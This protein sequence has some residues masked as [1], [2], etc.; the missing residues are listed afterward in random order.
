MNLFKHLYYWIKNRSRANMIIS[1]VKNNKNMV[2]SALP[3]LQGPTRRTLY[4]HPVY[5]E[6][7]LPLG[8]KYFPPPKK[9]FIKK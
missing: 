3:Q 4:V 6:H 9:T 1:N 5:H 8:T 2:I 7:S